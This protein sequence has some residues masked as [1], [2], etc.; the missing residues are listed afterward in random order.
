M[1]CSNTCESGRE[2]LVPFA[3]TGAFTDARARA[4]MNTSM[5]RAMGAQPPERDVSSSSAGAET[6]EDEPSFVRNLGIFFL[7][8]FL[9]VPVIVLAVAALF[10]LLLAELE[11]WSFPDGFYYIISMLCG[12]PNPLTDVDPDTTEG[13]IIDIVI[14]IW[15][16]ALAGT[17]IG[18][19][20]GMSVIGNLIESAEKLAQRKTKKVADEGDEKP[21]ESLTS[22]SETAALAN[23][24][25]ALEAAARRQNALLEKLLAK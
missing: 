18:I 1:A 19:V 21:F 17:I 20:G 8:V 16:L 22:G 14:A 5:T 3:R 2:S 23:R 10:G 9:I 11:G 25:A 7:F 4:D 24:V 13:R 12:L 15:A 6:E